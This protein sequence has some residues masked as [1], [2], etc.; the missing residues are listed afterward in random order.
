MERMKATIRK[1]GGHRAQSF[2]IWMLHITGLRNKIILFSLERAKSNKVNINYWSGNKNLGD[3]ISP[4]IVKFLAEANGIDLNRSVDATKHLYAVGS[5]ITAGC[6][7]CTIWGSGI[8]NTQILSRLR[9]RNFDIRLVRG[10][11]TRLVLLEHGFVVPENYGD[12][13]II[14]PMIYD[15]DVPKKYDVS[16]I[17]H[18]N[19]EFDDCDPGIHRISIRTDDFKHFVREI[20][21]SKRIISSSL[22]GIIFSETYGVPA[23]LLKPRMDLFKYFDYYYSTQRYDFPVAENFAEAVKA[24]APEIPDFMPMRKKIIATFPKDLWE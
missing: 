24:E 20:K 5:V 19:E 21:A 1:Y 10:P 18:M 7:D 11:L 22:H 4:V 13:A 9:N 3:A 23:V 12:P 14:M 6:Q 2:I 17:T 15:P 8:L 16:V